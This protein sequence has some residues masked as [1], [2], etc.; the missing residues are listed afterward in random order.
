MELALAQY[1]HNNFPGLL[2]LY[3][4]NCNTDGGILSLMAGFWRDSEE[5]PAGMME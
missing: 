1:G 3:E 4:N 2:R 5:I